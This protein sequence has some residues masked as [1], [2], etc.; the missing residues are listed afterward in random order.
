MVSKTLG[1][2]ITAELRKRDMSVTDFVGQ[3]EANYSKKYKIPG[4][5]H[6][7]RVCKGETYPGPNFLPI[8]CEAL[9]I[10]LED[11]RKMVMVDKSIISGT[12][13]ALTNKDT[14]LLLLENLW[15]NLS[16]NSRKELLMLAQM[17]SQME[18]T[19]LR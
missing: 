18:D 7:L 13:Q 5:N 16:Q 8:L 4:Y 10:N 12:A 2:R 15:G 11:A 19:S 6:V 17:K 1:T 9:D 14:E 3:L